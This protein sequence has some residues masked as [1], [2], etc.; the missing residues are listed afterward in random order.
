MA[1]AASRSGR[2][3][4]AEARG[5]EMQLVLTIYLL[6]VV[7]FTISSL[8]SGLLTRID[9]FG[10]HKVVAVILLWPFV[11]L[12]LFLMVLEDRFL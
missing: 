6:G 5:T 9:S 7:V 1:S 2:R 8:V 11:V 3:V 10:F 12:F 4:E